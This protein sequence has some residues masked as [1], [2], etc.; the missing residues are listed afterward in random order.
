MGRIGSSVLYTETTIGEQLRRVTKDASANPEE[1]KLAEEERHLR[2]L[3]LRTL[4]GMEI[5]PEEDAKLKNVGKR[6]LAALFAKDPHSLE[7]PVARCLA[8][9][10]LAQNPVGWTIAAT[11]EKWARAP[12][13]KPDD[14][15]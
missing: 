15:S 7:S 9:W 2:A 8:D 11:F 4:E 14:Y 10:G 3:F 5:K 6:K 13:P 1:K 12:R